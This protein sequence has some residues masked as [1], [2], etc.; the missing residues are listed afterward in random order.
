MNETKVIALRKRASILSANPVEGET[1]LDNN[2]VTYTRACLLNTVIVPRK[3]AVR[4]KQVDIPT[5]LLQHTERKS[6]WT[7]LKQMCHLLSSKKTGI[8]IRQ[9][10][11]L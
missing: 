10:W 2:T 5:E 7:C 8:L 9:T 1:M 4:D 6:H 11:S 3:A